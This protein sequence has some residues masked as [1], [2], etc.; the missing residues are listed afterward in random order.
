MQEPEKEEQPRPQG[1][2]IVQNGGR[3]NPWPRLLKYSTNVEYFVTWHMM[4]WLFRTLFPAS[5]GPICFLQSETVIQTKRRHFIV[6]AG[7]NSNELLEPFWQPW[8]GVSPTAILNE[9]KALGT[10][11]KE[12]RIKREGDGN[13]DYTNTRALKAEKGKEKFRKEIAKR[14]RLPRRGRQ[15]DE[16]DY[17]GSRKCSTPQTHF[18]SSSFSSRNFIVSTHRLY[19]TT[20]TVLTSQNECYLFP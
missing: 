5:G 19:K 10:R 7:Q 4:K 20:E 16:K 15:P 6:F 1:L 11:L 8:Q 12:E 14:Q 17:T 13:Q 9:E 2:L 18:C 3:R